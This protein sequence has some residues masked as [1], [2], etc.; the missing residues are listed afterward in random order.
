MRVF[1]NVKLALK[2]P[3]ATTKV[4]PLLDG[5]PAGRN[6]DQFVGRQERQL[7]E[8]GGQREICGCVVSVGLDRPA[9]PCDR[10]L[11]TAE[12]VLR[13]AREIHPA[14]SPRIARTETQ[15]LGDVGLGLFGAPRDLLQRKVPPRPYPRAPIR[16]APRYCQDRRRARDRKSCALAQRG[17]VSDPY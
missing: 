3:R 6:Q 15:G 7:R 11:I 2:S 5:P 12:L 16:R 1:I 17:Q 13:D 10:L 9:K 4:S 14:V 8:G